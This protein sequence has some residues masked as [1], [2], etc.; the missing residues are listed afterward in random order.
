MSEQKKVVLPV[1]A[2]LVSS[3][4][5]FEHVYK[6]M[7]D[8]GEKTLAMAIAASSKPASKRKSFSNTLA[9]KAIELC[10]H[11]SIELE[12]QVVDIQE[13]VMPKKLSKGDILFAN[14]ESKVAVPEIDLG[15]LA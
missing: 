7:D 15:F 4:G 6:P 10:R 1:T 13:S 14:G 2:Q 5:K 9:K 8:K 11:A 12:F 3:F